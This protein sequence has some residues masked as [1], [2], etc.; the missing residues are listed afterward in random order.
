MR[1]Y[2]LL[3]FLLCLVGVTPAQEK[4]GDNEAYQ[5]S[6]DDITKMSFLTDGVFSD[7]GTM[8]AWVKR[9]PSKEKN[10]YVSDLYLTRL[11][12]KN[13][14][15]SFKTTQLTRSDDSDS[16][17]V[18]STNGETIY[19]LSSRDEGKA[20]W[21]ISIW[22]GEP[23]KLDSFDVSISSLKRYNTN[24][25]AFEAEEGESY[26]EKQLEKANDDVKV[27]EDTTHFKT[28]RV[29]SYHIEEKTTVRLTDNEF[30][31]MEYAIA[32]NGQWLVTSHMMSPHYPADGQ[33]KPEYFL[34]DIANGT[35]TQILQEGFQTPGNFSF[36]S[37][38]SGFY[39]TAERS[40]DPEWNGA[41]ISLL[42]YFDLKEKSPVPVP[43]DHDWGLGM[44]YNVMGDHL[45]A[46]LA[47]GATDITAMYE[48]TADGWQKH[49]INAGKYDEHFRVLD[50][51]KNGNK[52]LYD[53][54]TA[55]TPTQ[56]R[57]SDFDNGRRSKTLSEGALLTDINPHLKKK[58]LVKSE[59]IYW[60]GALNEQVNGILYYP[61]DYDENKEYP[62]IVGIHGGPSG[63]DRDRW[64][65]RWA[66]YPHLMAERGVFF[67]KP[68]YHGSSNH[69]Q[70]FVESIKGH[71]YEYELED[72][73]NGINYL[74][75]QGKVDKTMMGVMGWSNGAILT[76]MLTVEYPGLFKAAAAGAGDVNWTSDFGTC[77]FGVTFDQSYFGGAPWDNTG[78]QIFN[79]NYIIKSPLFEMEKVKTP[80]IIFH[81]SEDRAVPRDQGWE[82]YRALQ[83]IG[84][85][86]VRFLWFPGQPHGLQKLSHQKR[87]MEEEI[88]WFDQYLFENE[89]D[90]LMEVFKEDSPLGSLITKSSASQQ[91][92]LF[93][94]LQEG[95]LIPEVA[96]LDADT[97][98]IGLFEV[99][100][101]QFKAYKGE[102]NFPAVEGNHPVSGLS[103][104]DVQGYLS[105]L[106]NLTGKQ[107]RLPN[108]NE[109]K[110]LQK[111][112]VEIGMK[113]NTLNY[114]AGY[115]ITVD[116][117]AAFRQKLKEIDGSLL[118]PVGS[119]PAIEIKDAKFFDV[120]GNVSE[121][122]ADGNTYGY[123]AYDY[124]D[125]K[126]ANPDRTNTRT[127]F[128]V[129][130]EK[131][132]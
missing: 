127:G 26:Y 132:N 48:K 16:N 78:S 122:D 108:A 117:V 92:G 33:P 87:K 97:I 45:V 55:S 89:P 66:Y 75:E 1:A 53:Y 98:S 94:L 44:G 38:V 19:F 64:G 102:H 59:V 27:I 12:I 113:E 67:L 82:Y 6:A 13:Q 120:G 3:C 52:W 56:Y 17:P 23:Y 81:G 72:I 20:I 39:F 9:R 18:F 110:A 80:T 91:E 123:S 58:P 65:D 42:Y 61:K 74:D 90:R 128:R 32:D 121:M 77:R 24:Y 30:P 131:A 104:S 103:L 50:I 114:W 49:T 76:T 85:A 116:E 28:S 119:F 62:L 5:W 79:E 129:I 15:G 83:Q 68:N 22:G 4:F 46:S 70:K 107:Y 36:L 71:Y 25:L 21:A 124:V 29:F 106:N 34:W 95:K 100:N 41:G 88:A 43:L 47:N 93:G 40:S 10:K 11:T 14:D 73:L 84:Q 109:A 99:T 60:E 115:E 130:L 69:G 101:A 63:V 96:A 111:K 125:K 86:P 8:V 2:L 7:E 35:K 118:M 31:I 37:S 112:A 105:W 57:I 126:E 54:S 51:S